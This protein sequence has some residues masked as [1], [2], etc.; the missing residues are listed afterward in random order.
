MV[1]ERTS[2]EEIGTPIENE[3]FFTF[4]SS[5]AKIKELEKKLKLKNH[6]TMIGKLS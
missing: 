3:I 6:V 1:E 5:F 4:R 2:D